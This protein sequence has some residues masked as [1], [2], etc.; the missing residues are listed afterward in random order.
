MLVTRPLVR[1]AHW[2][3]NVDHDTRSPIWGPWIRRLSRSVRLVR[4]DERGGGLSGDDPRPRGVEPWLEELQ[5]LINAAVDTR[6]DSRLALLRSAAQAPSRSPMRRA[7]PSGSRTWWCWAS[8]CMAPCT[9]AQPSSSAAVATARA[10]RR[11]WPM[12][13]NRGEQVCPILPSRLRPCLEHNE[14]LP[15]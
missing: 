7:T 5:A 13:W 10:P 3:T 14:H 9:A 15:A 6:R 8:T 4:H 11:R 12:R 1:V 2:L